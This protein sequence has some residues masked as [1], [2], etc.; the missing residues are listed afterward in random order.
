MFETRRVQVSGGDAPSSKKDRGT[1]LVG[2][3]L[4]AVLVKE[5]ADAMVECA[6]TPEAATTE[7]FRVRR[8]AANP[9]MESMDVDGES[10]FSP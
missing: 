1:M 9:L 6:P 10:A 3:P 4:Y 5:V 2:G 8:G 7:S